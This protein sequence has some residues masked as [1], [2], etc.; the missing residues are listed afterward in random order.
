M[1]KSKITVVEDLKKPEAE[2]ENGAVDAGE[3]VDFNTA[4]TIQQNTIK[5]PAGIAKQDNAKSSATGQD[6]DRQNRTKR[7]FISGMMCDSCVKHVQ[8]AL[9]AIDGVQSA[10]VVIG[11]ATVVL[12]KEVSDDALKAGVEKAGMYKVTSISVGGGGSSSPGGL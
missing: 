8:D 5:D 7:I 6:Q 11:R 2:G 4:K 10:E 12:N 3:P 1:I 9:S